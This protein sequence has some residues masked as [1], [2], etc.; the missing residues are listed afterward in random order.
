MPLDFR[1]LTPQI[2]RVINML[3][4]GYGQAPGSIL[5][6]SDLQCHL[7]SRLSRLRTL[8]KP[9]PTLDPYILGSHVHSELPWYDERGKL[10]IRPDLTIIEPEHMSILHGYAPPVIEPFGSAH[11]LFPAALPLPSKQCEFGGKAVILEL[12]FARTEIDRAVIEKIRYDFNKVMRLFKKLD[13]D[14]E[15]GN[16]FAFL[17]IFNKLPQKLGETLLAGFMREHG[18]GPRHRILYRACRPCPSRALRERR[19]SGY[20]DLIITNPP[21]FRDRA[22]R[23]SGE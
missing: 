4:L 16:V 14:G 10:R 1:T 21:Y 15:G 2:E 8:R 13:R 7:L 12:K 18:G 19:Y 23:Q 20:G 11:S 22:K 17:V 6:E 3:A 5:T 9:V